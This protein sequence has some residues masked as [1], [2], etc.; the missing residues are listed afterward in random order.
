MRLF[1]P[2]PILSLNVVD[3]AMLLDS[4]L[5]IFEQELSFSSNSAGRSHRMWRKIFELYSQSP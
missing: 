5:A 4:D 1:L 2:R 3:L